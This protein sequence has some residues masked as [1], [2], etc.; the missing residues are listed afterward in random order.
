M[1]EDEEKME[2]IKRKVFVHPNATDL[3]IKRMPKETVEIF[4]EYANKKF[5]GDYGF[6]FKSLVDNN[7]VED[8]K[9]SQ[10]IGI[11][12]DHEQR[13]DALEDKKA[14]KPKTKTMLSGRKI[15]VPKAE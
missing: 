5:V 3:H 7:L 11:L 10:L 12:D 1:T 14:S 6:A 4:K 13:L 2:E 8:V 15:T 9:Y